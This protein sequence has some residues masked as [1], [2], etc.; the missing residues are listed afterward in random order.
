MEPLAH[1]IHERLQDDLSRD[2]FQKRL[3]YASAGMFGQIN[4]DID[5][6]ALLSYSV[7]GVLREWNQLLAR[8]RKNILFEKI[9]YIFGAS[10]CGEVVINQLKKE[11]LFDKIN[12]RGFIDNNKSGTFM[13]YPVS[14]LTDIFAVGKNSIIIIAN[15]QIEHV[16]QIKKQIFDTF[17]EG[18]VITFLDH[19]LLYSNEYFG[20]FEPSPDEIFVDAGCFN[21]ETALEFV[22]WTNGQYK[23]IYAFEMEHN[24]FNQC[25]EILRPIPDCKIFQ[26]ALSDKNGIC[27]ISMASENRTSTNTIARIENSANANIPYTRCIEGKCVRLDDVLEISAPTFIKMDIEGAEAAALRGAAYTI[28]EYKPKLAIAIYHKPEDI[29][30]IPTLILEYNPQYK[31]FLRH[32]SPFSAETCLYAVM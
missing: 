10:Y 22:K 15:S 7:P 9:F 27:T 28:Q 6:V 25:C 1:K 17:F 32:Y 5:W 3:T 4:T 11:N 12:L 16:R 24:N 8:M 23:K 21:G 13:G 19:D 2:I 31:F 26:S 14:A 20:M 30:E 18:E 29:L